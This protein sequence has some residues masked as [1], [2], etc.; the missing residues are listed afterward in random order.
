MAET[1]KKPVGREDTQGSGPEELGQ[2]CAVITWLVSC[3]QT[4]LVYEKRKNINWPHYYLQ[5]KL[6]MLRIDAVMCDRPGTANISICQGGD[7]F[8]GGKLWYLL[9]LEKRLQRDQL[10]QWCWWNSSPTTTAHGLHVC[11]HTSSCFGPGGNEWSPE[12]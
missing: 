8:L 2:S 10:L 3:S 7:R 1:S 5:N 11:F 9:K 12:R 6:P 4:F